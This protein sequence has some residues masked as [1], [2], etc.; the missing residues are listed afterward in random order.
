MP[1][2]DFGTLITDAFGK[3]HDISKGAFDSYSM[4]HEG[5]YEPGFSALVEKGFPGACQDVLK[6]FGVSADTLE[7]FG[8]ENWTDKVVSYLEDLTID[9]IAGI[10]PV[11]AEAGPVGVAL[12][13]VAA[14][15]TPLL[16]EFWKSVKTKFNE[17]PQQNYRSGQWVGIDNG[18]SAAVKG[19]HNALDNIFDKRRRMFGID[20]SRPPQLLEDEEELLEQ[21]AGELENISTGFYLGPGTTDDTIQ[22]FNL[23]KSRD[24]QLPIKNVR[25]L[26]QG[27]AKKLD[28]SEVWSEIRLL[29]FNEERSELLQGPN[30]DPGS[31]VV[32]NGEPFFVVKNVGDLIQIEHKHTHV[33]QT[34]PYEELSAGRREHNNAWNYT[35]RAPRTFDSAGEAAYSQGD[36]VWIPPLDEIRAEFPFCTRQLACIQFLSGNTWIGYTAVDG[37]KVQRALSDDSVF[38]VTDDLR[39][40]LEQT[41]TFAVFRDA[42]VR[43]HDLT[44]NAAGRDPHFTNL[45][46]GITTLD[47]QRTQKTKPQWRSQAEAWKA[48]L[49]TARIRDALR[50]P[51]KVTG[52]GGLA[53]VIDERNARE[54]KGEPGATLAEIVTPGEAEPKKPKND[55][56]MGTVA[57]FLVCGGVIYYMV[58]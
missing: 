32:Y 29:R 24:E 57:A 55:V 39:S 3:F 52:D 18:K 15:A 30:C 40:T 2:G 13:V 31:E 8:T 34:V 42:V 7:T 22:V 43:G 12:S 33:Q 58:S 25:P 10:A 38:A 6:K 23:L 21:Q 47:V 14:T 9:G 19:L 49:D 27:E 1:V 35:A 46:L 51:A 26:G 28:D 37:T 41:R 54:I 17:T 36:Y 5:N 20:Y 44:N 48:N 50:A 45:C 56:G 16:K 4:K 11:A 53:L